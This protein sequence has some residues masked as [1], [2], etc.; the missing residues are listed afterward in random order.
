M[1]TPL[2]HLHDH[3]QAG[4]AVD[5][6]TAER[7]TT[8]KHLVLSV[9]TA[10]DR[11]KWFLIAVLLALT[12]FGHLL[13]ENRLTDR[14]E[15]NV[16]V[17]WIKLYPNGTSDVSFQEE[18]TGPEFFQATVDYF[19]RD[20]V[21]RRFSKVP[22]S[23]KSDYGF[24]ALM[25]APPLRNQFVDPTQGNA[26]G[27]AAKVE[28]CGR[29]DVTKFLIR[30]VD[31]F[32]FDKTTFA[33]GVKGSLYRTNVFVTERIED[34]DGKVKPERRLIVS[35]QWRV[36]TKNEALAA[37]QRDDSGN[38]DLTP[39]KLNPASIEILEEKLLDDPS[40]KK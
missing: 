23:I 37:L 16:R 12:Q 34:A 19:L 20:Y 8:A 30:D 38:L 39:L 26:P 1:A 28:T 17:V 21:T 22:H 9:A 15:N 5:E 2:P 40:G 24:A 25:M 33:G 7:M 10:A 4:T 35:L 18:S 13:Y 14:L 27:V 6:P 29:C 3:L 32:D 31:H 11:N 36:K